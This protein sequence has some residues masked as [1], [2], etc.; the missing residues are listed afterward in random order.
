MN[1]YSRRDGRGLTDCD[2]RIRKLVQR[3]ESLAS[4]YMVAMHHGN[5]DAAA[6]FECRM[7]AVSERLAALVDEIN[8]TEGEDK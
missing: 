3:R 2:D 7:R 4:D 1:Y 5:Y 8:E 6:D